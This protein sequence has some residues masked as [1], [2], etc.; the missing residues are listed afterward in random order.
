M[1]FFAGNS[2]GIKVN[3]DQAGGIAETIP[4]QLFN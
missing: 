1:R 3:I 4:N 2:R